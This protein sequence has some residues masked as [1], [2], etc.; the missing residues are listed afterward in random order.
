MTNLM[1]NKTI[2]EN[3]L[4]YCETV[5]EHKADLHLLQGVLSRYLQ[6]NLEYF[7][8]SKDDII[9]IAEIC[10]DQHGHNI[11][12]NNFIDVSPSDFLTEHK[13]FMLKW[14]HEEATKKPT[15]QTQSVAKLFFGDL[16]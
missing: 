13:V 6:S 10:N 4:D 5:F 16:A 12:T 3:F 11:K 8:F 14:D 9:A 7:N 1:A 15:K 2:V